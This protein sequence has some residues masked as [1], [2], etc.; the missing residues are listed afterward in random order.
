M[1]LKTRLIEYWLTE[2]T[3]DLFQTD[4]AD[5]KACDKLFK[6]TKT[7]KN[8]LQNISKTKVETITRQTQIQTEN[9]NTK[10]SY[11]ADFKDWQQVNKTNIS[12]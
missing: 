1:F 2:L 3:I 12:Y 4:K 7:C 10:Y 5:S 6:A 8:C 9:Q 11:V